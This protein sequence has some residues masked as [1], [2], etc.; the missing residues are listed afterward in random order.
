MVAVKNKEFWNL[1]KTSKAT[2]ETAQG[3]NLQEKRQKPI[4]I[5]GDLCKCLC[6]NVVFGYITTAHAE[7]HG[8]KNQKAMVA[9]GKARFV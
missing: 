4:R 2:G 7:S 8:F 3:I 9:A 1:A 5:V 6:C